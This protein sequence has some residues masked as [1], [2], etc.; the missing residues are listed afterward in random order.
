VGGIEK[1]QQ[2]RKDLARSLPGSSRIQVFALPEK[3]NLDKRDGM[4]RDLEMS[5]GLLL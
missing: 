5:L 1:S 4:L 2:K 3:G